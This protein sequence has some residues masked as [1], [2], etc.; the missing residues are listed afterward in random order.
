MSGPWWKK[1]WY[2]FVAVHDLQ[3]GRCL[4]GLN[5]MIDFLGV[6]VYDLNQ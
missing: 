5:V 1:W 2:A 3:A 6:A 4:S